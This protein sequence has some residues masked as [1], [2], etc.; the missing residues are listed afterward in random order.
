MYHAHLR[1]QAKKHVLPAT[2]PVEVA[3]LLAAPNASEGKIH[4]RYDRRHPARAWIEGMGW[5]DDNSIHWFSIL[6]L[7]FQAM[8]TGLLLLLLYE[9]GKRGTLP[10]WWSLYQPLPLLVEAF[11][12]L[13]MGLIDRFMP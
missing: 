1:V 8:L 11:W 2:L 5:K 12:M 6:T 10:W 9:R 7:L 13:V 3:K 4:V